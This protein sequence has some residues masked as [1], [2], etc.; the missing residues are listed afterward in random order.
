MDTGVDYLNPDFQNPDGTTRLVSI[1]DQTGTGTH[2]SG[3]TYGAEWLPADINALIPSEVDSQGHGSHVL[4]IAAGN[5]SA[6]GNGQPAYTYVGM[7]PQADLCMVKTTF[8]TGAIVDGVHYIFQKAASLGKQAVVNLSLGTQEGPHDGTLD[9]DV[10][11]NALTGP[12]KIIVAS[13]GNAGEDNLH[14]QLT[15]S[16][17]TPQNM[18]LV[19]PPYTPAPG[20]ANDVL[21]FSGWY[22][23]TS[24]ISLRIVT[25]RACGGARNDVLSKITVCSIAWR[26]ARVAIGRTRSTFA[27]APSMVGAVVVRPYSR[28]SNSDR[29]NASDSSSVKIKGGSL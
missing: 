23:G 25:I 3:F 6:T 13:A 15:L 19:V 12:G 22:A 14:G 2:P 21:L 5:G 4:G 16:G 20:T 24:Q 18:T 11:L 9:M 10:M 17:S 27:S 7:A 29:V 8:Q 26:R 28:A 1:W